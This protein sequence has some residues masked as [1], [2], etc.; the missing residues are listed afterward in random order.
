MN[1]NDVDIEELLREE[2]AEK[3]EQ[4]PRKPLLVDVGEIVQQPPAVSWLIR[5]WLPTGVFAVLFGPS[6]KGK[7]FLALDMLA[8]IAT[9]VD[10]HG[11]KTTPGIAAY[12]CGEGFAGIGKRLASWQIRNEQQL[13]GRMFASASIPPLLDGGAE[14]IIEELGRLPDVPKVI[15]LDTV[16][17][18]L[19]GAN[20]NDSAD[21]AQFVSACDS[22]R[23]AAPGSTLIGIHHTGWSDPSRARGSSVLRAAVDVEL[24]CNRDDHGVIWLSCTKAKDTEEPPKRGFTLEKITLPWED[25]EGEPVTSAILVGLSDAAQAILA[26]STKQLGDAQKICLS[27]LRKMQTETGGRVLIRDWRQRAHEEGFKGKFARVLAT[28]K[29][30]GLVDADDTHAWAIGE[31]SPENGTEGTKG[32]FVPNDSAGDAGQKGQMSK[33]MSQLSPG[34]PIEKESSDKALKKKK[35]PRPKTGKKT[36]ATRKSTTQKGA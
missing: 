9:G 32:T 24:A 8:C 5:D 16:S 13:A 34:V 29:E 7:S 10:F 12:F 28:L 11:H 2:P 6:G 3:Q 15:A 21:M 17:R 31:D 35:N 26:A 4:E 33:D 25:D 27:V 1:L 20:E 22:I 36:P 18:A 14:R 30:R 19:G 23:A